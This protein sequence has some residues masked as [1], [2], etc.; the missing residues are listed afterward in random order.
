MGSLITQSGLGGVVVCVETDSGAC[1][2]EVK[3]LWASNLLEGSCRST[4]SGRGRG[5]WD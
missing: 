4:S 2:R 3:L 1:P 5:G